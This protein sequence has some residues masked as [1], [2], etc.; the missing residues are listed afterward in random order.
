[1]SESVA[2]LGLPS[3]DAPIAH[4]ATPQ[5]QSFEIRM[6]AR[7]A[8][9]CLERAAAALSD[10]SIVEARAALD[11]ARQ[12]APQLPRL[13]ELSRRLDALTQPAPQALAAQGT[14]GHSYAWTSAAV[15][16]GLVVFSAA[17]WQAWG[18]R[19][20]IAL[21]V[22]TAHP[23][24]DASSGLASPTPANVPATTDVN[25]PAASASNP[26]PSSSDTIV[27]TTLVRADH[28]IEEPATAPQSPPSNEPAAVATA[29]L[30]QPSEPKVD[31]AKTVLAPNTSQPAARPQ[32]ELAP[33]QTPPAPAVESR[34]AVSLATL[35]GPPP[36]TNLI[37]PIVAPPEPSRP[38]NATTTG[39]GTIAATD[40]AAASPEPAALRPSSAATAPSVSAPS[41]PVR[42]DRVAVRA[43]LSRYESAYNRLD[44]DAVR[45]VWPSLDQRALARAFD[46]L[47]AQRVALQNC[48]VDV[49]GTIAR[50]SCSGN[51]SWTP[52]VGGGERSAARNWTF[53]LRESNGAWRITQ[54]RAR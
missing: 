14:Q 42:D 21:L 1:M 48:N 49:D 23:D 25:R 7:K 9:R 27:Q 34:P 46:N 12:L 24:M 51:A 32:R 20:Q 39:N 17:G 43:A 11:E 26:P 5:W 36:A 22:P 44:V 47:S 6:R 37:P 45:T 18:H 4:L 3:G 50:A 35:S 54:V 53:D 52:K 40:S 15:F 33:S 31:A 2:D 41:S 29:G 8:D 13:E 19:D 30:A 10:G 16:A 38:A 28:V